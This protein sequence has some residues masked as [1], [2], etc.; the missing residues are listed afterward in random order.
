MYF[1]KKNKPT[2]KPM[3]KTFTEAEEDKYISLNRKPIL[4][5]KAII[6]MALLLLAANM[7][8]V[9]CTHLEET[10]AQDGAGDY[11]SC[12]WCGYSSNKCYEMSCSQCGRSR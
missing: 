10:H 1:I 8:S 6:I 2:V 5:R 12:R 3:E 9:F 11:W 4:T 7:S